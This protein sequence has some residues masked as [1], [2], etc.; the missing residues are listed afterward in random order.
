MALFDEILDRTGAIGARIQGY[1]LRAERD[2]VYMMQPDH[3]PT[4][5]K[6]IGND[7]ATIVFDAA[8]EIVPEFPTEVTEFP[9]EDGSEISDHVINKHPT[10]RF[11]AIVSDYSSN[12]NTEKGAMS[13]RDAYQMLLKMRDDRK[14]VSLLTPVATYES[15]IITNVSFPRKSGDGL[16]LFVDLNL[17]QI[18]KVKSDFKSTTVKVTGKTSG[19]TSGDTE[20]KTTPSQSKGTNIPIGFAKPSTTPVVGDTRITGTTLQTRALQG[21]ELITNVYDKATQ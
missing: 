15:L 18:R 14:E 2:R 9:V 4:R 19:K 16:S 11:T 8:T 13:Q 3:K 7:G 6:L 5:S 10:F 12:M 21:Y 17:T 20:I 1:N